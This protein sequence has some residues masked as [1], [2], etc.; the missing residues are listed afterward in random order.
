MVEKIF[1]QKKDR[2]INYFYRMIIKIIKISNESSKK[3]C[4][5]YIIIHNTN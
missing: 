2:I 3:Q 1:F 5:K 4:E